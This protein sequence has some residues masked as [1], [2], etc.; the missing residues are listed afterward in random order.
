MYGLAANGYLYVFDVDREKLI[1][2]VP[3]KMRNV[4]GIS[5]HPLRNIMIAYN[6]D[7]DLMIY[8]PWERKM[9]KAES[10]IIACYLDFFPLVY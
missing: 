10:F 2:S 3:M 8:K 4:S 6:N 1:H 5:H 9:G 7:G